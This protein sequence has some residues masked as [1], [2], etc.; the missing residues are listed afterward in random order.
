M[1]DS[2]TGAVI[3]RRVRDA[4]V[5]NL[6]DIFTADTDYPYVA[7]SDGT[8]NFD[9]TKIAIN[10]V[11]PNDHLYYP[12]IICSTLSGEE[13]RFLQEDLMNYE[14]AEDGTITETRGAPLV[15]SCSIQG[16]SLDT[17]TRD[18]LLDKIYRNFKVITDALAVNGV[19]VVKTSLETDKREFIQDRWIYS[20]G[21]RME[22]FGEWTDLVITGPDGTVDRI[23]GAISTPLGIVQR[24]I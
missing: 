24:F 6:R 2:L 18:A 9:L 4:I 16:Q 11:T 22:L 10:D 1:A 12:S 7:N 5:T 20:S 15:F 21:V 23:T 3:A 8:L 14:V 13:E 19:A 17:I